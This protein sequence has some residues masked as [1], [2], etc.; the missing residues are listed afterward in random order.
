[1]LRIISTIAVAL[2]VAGCGAKV[3]PVLSPAPTPAEVQQVRQIGARIADGVTLGLTLVDDTGR[4]LDGLPLST[5]LKDRYDCAALR[6]TGL[7]APSATVTR[8][9]GPLPTLAASPLAL[10]RTKLA[11]VTTCPSLRATVA[12]VLGEI[13]PFIVRLSLSENPSLVFAASAI[14]TAFAYARSFLVGG[15]ECWAS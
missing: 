10:A 6:L 14:R 7:D 13:D 12:V 11:A 5:E 4:L 9:C 8:V 1:M 2:A 3:P 15:G